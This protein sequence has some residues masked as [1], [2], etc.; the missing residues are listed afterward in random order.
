MAWDL[1]VDGKAWADGKNVSGPFLT[2]FMTMECTYSYLSTHSSSERCATNDRSLLSWRGRCSTKVSYHFGY[3][4]S[5]E[6]LVEV[7]LQREVRT[8]RRNKMSDHFLLRL[9]KS[10][11][12]GDNCFIVNT[13]SPMSEA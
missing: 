7:G 13:T 2:V 6:E 1:S 4:G 5:M 8:C 12:G 10:E 11:D 9:Q 3:A